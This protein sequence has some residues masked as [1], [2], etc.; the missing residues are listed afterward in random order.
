MEVLTKDLSRGTRH[1]K[2]Q[3]VRVT[4]G[5]K[6]VA[7]KLERREGEGKLAPTVLVRKKIKLSTPANPDWRQKKEGVC[8]LLRTQTPSS[9]AIA[10]EH[11]FIASEAM[12]NMKGQAA[13]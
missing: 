4:R 1:A 6:K 13:S 5:Q 9:L 11:D 12:K 7:L 2:T 10:S 3:A 8:A